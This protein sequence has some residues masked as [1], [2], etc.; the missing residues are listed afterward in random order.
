MSN[1]GISPQSSQELHLLVT[2]DAEL[3]VLCQKW[4]SCSLLAIDTE[5]I[6][7]STF[8]PQPGLVQVCD[9]EQ[10]YLLDPLALTDWQAFTAIL[11][12]PDIVKIMH[13]CSEDLVVFQ[14]AFGVIPANIFDTQKA[15]AFLGYG[16]SLSYQNLIRE[17]LGIEL[18]KGETRSDWLQRPLSQE[19]LHYAIQ[20]VS[21]LPA[22]FQRQTEALSRRNLLQWCHTE[23]E[24]LGRICALQEEKEQWALAYQGLVAGWRLQGDNLA[25]LQAL[26]L[27]REEQA[28]KRN[29]PRNW[30][31]KDQE[32]LSMAELMPS[33]IE[34]LLRVPGLPSNLLKHHADT[35][36]S[37]LQGARTQ[38]KTLMP[39]PPPLTPEERKLIKSCQ[40]LVR[41]KAAE[42][43]IAEELL[44]RKRHLVMILRARKQEDDGWPI[45]IGGWQRE[46]LEN[47]IA[48]VIADD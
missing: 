17:F 41:E 42:L 33:S 22:I 14:T 28:R 36:L 29:K 47:D 45:E 43:G 15:A 7:I 44:A 10:S 30:V 4:L 6:R 40:H 38:H 3:S 46:L 31:A 35:L 48:R 2:D 13:S 25:A 27:W 23:C 1:H 20:D 8:Y 24:Q 32:L 26:C 11:T 5:F 19:Q 16:Y 21:F 37:C 18:E 39:I 12:N 34:E 9:G